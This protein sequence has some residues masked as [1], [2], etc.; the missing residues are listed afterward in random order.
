M[1]IALRLQA[2]LCP[3]NTAWQFS[4]WKSSRQRRCYCTSYLKKDAFLK[5]QSSFFW[6]ECK[7]D[8]REK[9]HTK[10]AETSQLSHTYYILYMLDYFCIFPG[11]FGLL[12]LLALCPVLLWYLTTIFTD[13][14]GC[15]SCL[16]ILTRCS[17]S[18]REA[19]CLYSSHVKHSYPKC[20]KC[21]HSFVAKEFKALLVF[22]VCF[23]VLWH[24]TLYDDVHNMN[25]LYM[26][27]YIR[28]ITL[29]CMMPC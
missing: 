2:Q 15:F 13:G 20:N 19:C 28:F 25:S 23:G 29:H 9:N 8:V 14:W 3:Q 7:T 18:S 12:H 26:M 22:H 5:S 17:T 16:W 1:V 10:M 11:L 24:I 21:W 27:T 6:E 4:N